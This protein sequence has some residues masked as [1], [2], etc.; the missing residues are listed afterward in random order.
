MSTSSDPRPWRKRHPILSRVVLFGVGGAIVAAILLL[1]QADQRERR[2]TE[3]RGLVASYDV[4]L[5]IES[6]PQAVLDSIAKD[7]SDPDLPA[8]L[9][10]AARR[11]EAMALR[12]LVRRGNAPE[13]APERIH[14]ALNEARA[15]A[16]DRDTR[17]GL[18][19]EQAEAYLEAEDVAK[20]REALA[21]GDFGR[22]GLWAVLRD[23]YL[24]IAEAVEL[25]P[26]AGAKRLEALLGSWKAP[27][28]VDSEVVA[29]GRRW[30][31]PQVATITVERLARIYATTGKDAGPLWERLSA[32][33]ALDAREQLIAVK[34]LMESGLDETAGKGLL[35]AAAR[36]PAETAAWIEQDPELG[37]LADSVNLD[38]NSLKGGAGPSR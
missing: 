17:N 20:A 18:R 27:L 30:N 38:P 5:I 2:I 28:P 10:M 34:R 4:L 11:Y 26:E 13:G 8:D 33:A 37:R 14:V 22:D 3:L 24:A 35:N 19:L 23:H 6:G 25:G 1:W 36:D 16:G 7:L 21:A 31:L 15:L 29:G 12:Q 9:R 32:L